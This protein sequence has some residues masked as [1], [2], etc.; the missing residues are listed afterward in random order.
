MSE[1]WAS[2]LSE[3]IQGSDAVK[4]SPDLATYIESTEKRVSDLSDKQARS[5]YNPGKDASE[6]DRA[7]FTSVMEKIGFAP[8]E[9]VPEKAS[10]YSVEAGDSESKGK[11]LEVRRQRYH[12]EGIGKKTA[13]KLLKSD[14]GRYDE[15]IS[16]IGDAEGWAQ[17]QLVKLWGKD[18]A[19][20]KYK[21]ALKGAGLIE[22]KEGAPTLDKLMEMPLFTADGQVLNLREYPRL[23]D[24]V[25]DFASK[26]G[27]DKT[28]SG[29]LNGA[30][31][32]DSLE[33]LQTKRA[34]AYS[35]F[36]KLKAGDPL[37]KEKRKEIQQLSSQ[38]AAAKTGNKDLSG[39][40]AKQIAAGI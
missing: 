12:K 9:S 17:D 27:E 31:G 5:I 19:E 2:E 15:M 11:W 34:V 16:G 38:I 14:G 40:T 8:K 37:A 22:G 21:D 4:N 28:G 3:D 7:K 26:L 33:G 20:Q 24:M 36:D 29:D 13:E 10:D 18:K 23:M 6:D 30:T 25:S 1:H 35:E 32:V 39:M